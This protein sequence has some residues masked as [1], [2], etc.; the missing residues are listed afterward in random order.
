[1][2]LAP[3]LYWRLLLEPKLEKILGRILAKNRPLKSKD[4]NIVILVH[5]RG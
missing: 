3:A 2:V 4:I 5:E 1:M